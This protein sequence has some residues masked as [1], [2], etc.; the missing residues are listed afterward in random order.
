[1]EN[2]QKEAVFSSGCL[3]YPDIDVGRAKDEG[4]KSLCLI[5]DGKKGYEKI[6]RHLFVL[7][8]GYSL[9]KVCP[10]LTI[11]CSLNAIKPQSQDPAVPRKDC[12]FES[13]LS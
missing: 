8:V 7:P 13:G 6:Y 12:F 1:M 11:I 5:L 10:T 4:R 3:S 2:V 9:C